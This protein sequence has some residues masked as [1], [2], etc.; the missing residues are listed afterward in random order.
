VILEF[1]ETLNDLFRT[2]AAYFLLIGYQVASH[3]I[4]V[5]YALTG[6]DT[7]HSFQLDPYCHFEIT[8]HDYFSYLWLNGV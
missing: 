5:G 7:N 1:L 2:V 8:G 4:A 6:Y 3:K